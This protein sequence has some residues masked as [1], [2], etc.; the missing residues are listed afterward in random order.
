M[1][2]K[3]FNNDDGVEIRA[4]VTYEGPEEQTEPPTKDEVLETIRT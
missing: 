3:L 2:I 4:E 1:F